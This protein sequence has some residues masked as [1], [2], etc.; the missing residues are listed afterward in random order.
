[1]KY[2]IHYVVRGPGSL[3][4][5][6]NAEIEREKPICSI[7]DIRE[8]E[9]ALTKGS[10]AAIVRV[11]N[12]QRFE[13]ETMSREEIKALLEEGVREGIELA[14]RSDREEVEYIPPDPASYKTEIPVSVDWSAVKS[15]ENDSFNPKYGL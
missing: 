13:Y 9:H 2:F 6:I 8:I 10:T 3:E 1:M 11:R 5:E 4:T 15:Q 7:Q 12:W 14:L